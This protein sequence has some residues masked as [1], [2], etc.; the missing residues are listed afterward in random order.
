[1]IFLIGAT[2]FLGFWLWW[3]GRE[4]KKVE[5]EKIGFLIIWVL[6]VGLFIR[7]GFMDVVYSYGP[8]MS[9][10]LP[11]KSYMVVNKAVFGWSFPLGHAMNPGREPWREEIVL[12]EPPNTSNSFLIKRVVG[13]PGDE[14]A[15]NEDTL[16]LNKKVIRHQGGALREIRYKVSLQN[17]DYFVVG[18]HWYNSKDS[19]F[20]GPIRHRR[21]IGTVMWVNDGNWR[22][23]VASPHVLSVKN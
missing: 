15:W 2:W 5:C 18:D 1:M 11:E 19:R 22:G 10:T 9:P 7:S 17:D 20:F 4:A 12:L 21:L 14:L 23:V 16:W 6:P 8:S 3:Y 13:L